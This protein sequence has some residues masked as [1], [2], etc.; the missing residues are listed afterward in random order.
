ML[1]VMGLL[2]EKTGKVLKTAEPGGESGREEAPTRPYVATIGPTTQDYLRRTFNFE[3]DV[4]SEKPAPEA[5]CQ[6][7]IGF[8]RGRMQ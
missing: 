6:V 1:R 4:C 8:T 2:D 7:I 3:P 5:L